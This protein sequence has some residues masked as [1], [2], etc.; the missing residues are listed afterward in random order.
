MPS[1]S[2][3]NVLAANAVVANVLAGSQYEFAPFNGNM[4]IGLTV[5]VAGPTGATMAIFAGP[6]V[7]AE[8][9]SPI[10]PYTTEQFPKYPDDY[11]WEDMV[12]QGDRLKIGLAAGS[13]G[14]TVN[15]VLRIN[16][17]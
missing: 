17:V 5:N 15:W 10:P 13:A 11:H 3:R 9:G 2:G 1:I 16:P 8:P 6:D 14:A 4:Q 7:L 12:A